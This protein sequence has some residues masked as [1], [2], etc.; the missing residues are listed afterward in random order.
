[1]RNTVRRRAF[2]CSTRTAACCADGTS[3]RPISPDR[4]GVGRSDPQ[5][6]RSVVDSASGAAPALYG[7]L[8][9]RQL[10]P[11]DAT[12][13][14]ENGFSAFGR[15]SHEA[16][17]QPAGAVE[18]YRAWMRPWGFAPEDLRVPVDVWA[19]SEDRI[20]DTAWQEQLFSRIPNARLFVREDGHLVAHRHYAEI[21][22]TLRGW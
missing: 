9:A 22:E 17:R 14:R 20:V 2:R 3:P 18:E 4:P 10:G 16:A 6:C 19:G 21:F 1:M 7:R 5:P 15:M 11:A 13:L 8:A 12:V